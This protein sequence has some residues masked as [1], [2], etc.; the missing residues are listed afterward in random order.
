[1]DTSFSRM[2]YRKLS[3]TDVLVRWGGEEFLV[4]MRE[5]SPAENAAIAEKLRTAIYMDA[6]EKVGQLSISIGASNMKK[7][8]SFDQFINRLDG[9]LYQAKG[10][11]RNQVAAG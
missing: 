4:I 3:K 10:N 7:D 11:G 6:F 5:V 8:E 2:K 1:M 9:L